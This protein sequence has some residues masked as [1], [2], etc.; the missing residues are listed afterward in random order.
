M[1]ETPWGLALPLKKLSGVKLRLEN[2]RADERN[3]LSSGQKTKGEVLGESDY[4]ISSI[5]NW[6]Y[7]DFAELFAQRILKKDAERVVSN[8]TV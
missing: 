1:Q 5:S 8:K 2:A 4:G 7:D 3:R 6:F